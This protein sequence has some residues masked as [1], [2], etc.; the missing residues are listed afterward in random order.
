[1]PINNADFPISDQQ[2]DLKIDN[3]VEHVY[4]YRAQSAFT[5]YNTL[6]FY[7]YKQKFNGLDT[8]IS[9]NGI[10]YIW[11]N[12]VSENTG[13]WIISIKIGTAFPGVPANGMYGNT[14]SNFFITK[15]PIEGN[16]SNVLSVVLSKITSDTR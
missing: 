7:K 3:L 6:R 2:A 5:N 16:Y 4:L 1:M 11:A 15:F 8:F 9:E 13:Q 12:R 14:D 10:Y